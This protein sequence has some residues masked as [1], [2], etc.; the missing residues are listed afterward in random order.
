MRS[1]AWAEPTGGI[2]EW[3][4]GPRARPLAYVTLGTVV[5]G[6]VDSLRAAVHGLAALDIDVLVTV[7]PN[8]DPDALG[9]V[10]E[11]VHVERFVP[12]DLL[13]PHVD[14]LLHHCGSGTMLG[15]F[16]QGLPQLALPHGADQFSNAEVLLRSGAG[17]RL[18][19]SEITP[20]AITECT[21][22]LLTDEAYGR[23]AHGLATEMAAMP[24]PA[25]VVPTLQ[26]MTRR[27]RSERTA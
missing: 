24:A 26:H 19:P 2:P 21:Q 17:L 6:A 23:A 4:T 14:V 3:I 16:A 7:G 22:A 9:P 1:V 8:G 10:P 15:G 11:H 18:R 27:A 13:L 12:Q 25:S 20:A 5:Y